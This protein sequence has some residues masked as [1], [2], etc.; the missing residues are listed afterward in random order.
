MSP[1]N[2]FAAL[3]GY[4]PIHPWLRRQQNILEDNFKIFKIKPQNRESLQRASILAY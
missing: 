3:Y 1:N 4:K 2:K